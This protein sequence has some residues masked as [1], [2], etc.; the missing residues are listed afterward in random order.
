M[1]NS[2]Y[3]AYRLIQSPLNGGESVSN[4]M[5]ASALKDIPVRGTL[6][7]TNDLRYPANHF[8]RPEAQM[9]FSALF[10]H[11]MYVSN[12]HYLVPPGFGMHAKE[13]IAKLPPKLF[14]IKD[15]EFLK[16]RGITH[17]IQAICDSSKTEIP[18]MSYR[19][20]NVN[21]TIQKLNN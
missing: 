16:S 6:L 7:A 3:T 12:L 20:F 9:Q 15:A 1:S 18:V 17:Y 5:L 8:H 2:V 11:Q 13:F 19:V 21:E 4:I 10:G 14:D